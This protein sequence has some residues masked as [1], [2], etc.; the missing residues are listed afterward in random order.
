[1]A[2]FAFLGQFSPD[3]LTSNVRHRAAHCLS[4][5]TCLRFV[6]SVFLPHRWF[7]M[8]LRQAK[9]TPGI[10]CERRVSALSCMSTQARLGADRPARVGASITARRLFSVVEFRNFTSFT[11]DEAKEICSPNWR[12]VRLTMIRGSENLRVLRSEER[13]SVRQRSGAFF[14]LRLSSCFSC[15]LLSPKGVIERLEVRRDV[16]AEVARVL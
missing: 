15:G 8:P 4:L 11:F 14:F 10:R 9:E 5:P 12:R 6:D 13:A 3:W 7:S 16:A 1:V 2:G